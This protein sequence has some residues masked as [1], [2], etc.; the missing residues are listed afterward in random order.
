MS[1]S[2]NSNWGADHSFK[3]VGL[4]SIVVR[5]VINLLIKPRMKDYELDVKDVNGR[6]KEE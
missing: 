2:L 3:G 1:P 6:V 4:V 5:R